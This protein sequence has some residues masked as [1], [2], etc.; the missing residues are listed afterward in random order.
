MTRVITFSSARFDVSDET[1]NPIN[2]IFGERLLAFVADATRSLGWEVTPPAPEDWGW[3]VDVSRGSDAYM[4]GASG[5]AE[6]GETE[7]DWTIQIHKRRTI[8]DRLTRRNRFED[9]DALVTAIESALLAGGGID[10][11]A[12]HWER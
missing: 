10:A 11:Y 12:S 7:I 4:V 6:D 5:E 1:P 3:Y 2:P 8:V 9:G